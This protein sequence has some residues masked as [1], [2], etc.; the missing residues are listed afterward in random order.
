M[1]FDCSVFFCPVLIGF[2]NSLSSVA[3]SPMERILLYF[4]ILLFVHDAAGQ[5][6]AALLGTWSDESLVGSNFYNNIYNEVWGITYGG[7]EYAI[8]GSTAGTHFIDVT[9]PAS[10]FEAHFVAGAQQGG[11]IIHRDYHDRNGFL[12]AVADEGHS[13]LQIIDFRGLPGL[14]EVVYDS[15]SLISQTHNIFIERN[16]M[17]A[18]ATSGSSIGDHAMRVFD[19]SDPTQPEFIAEYNEFGD[20]SAGHV[21]DGYVRNGIAFLNCGGDGMAIVDFNDRLAPKTLFDLQEYPDQ[22][23]NHSGWLSD[24]GNY[25]YM[26]DENHTADLKVLD[27]SEPCSTTVEGT[28][29]AEVSNM[30]SIT[31]NQIVAC[32]YL[33]TS[34]YYDGLQVFDISD[35]TDPQK[36]LYYDTYSEPDGQSYKGAWGVYP[37]LP[38]GNILV[39]DMQTGLYILEGP[40]D[41]CFSNQVLA[42]P[43]VS[44]GVSVGIGESIIHDGHKAYPQPVKAGSVLTISGLDKGMHTD[45][46]LYRSDGAQL[47]NWVG[48]DSGNERVV[49]DVPDWLP[50]GVYFVGYRPGEDRLLLPVIIY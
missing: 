7:R 46:V 39:S 9:E 20:L 49:L 31:H 43:D 42:G 25:Y 15:D 23:Y 47:H 5:D 19:I 37:L 30:L 44:C 29:D 36:V 34:F 13:T 48:I 8:I 21:H 2:S 26:A 40:G 22:G 28:F 10:A 24:D 32:N 1:I 11:Q 6:Q 45:L 38:S 50:S 16:T 18:F 12:Y 33:Y 27:V 41:G 14:I 17:Y 4:A 3:F 35:P